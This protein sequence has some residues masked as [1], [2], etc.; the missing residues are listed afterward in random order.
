MKLNPAKC[1]FGVPAGKLLGYIVS[2]RGIEANP[3]KI[4]AIMSL[5]KPASIKDIQ[6]L[7]GCVASLSR[8]ISQLGEKAI[9]LYRL[10]RKTEKFIWD[11][12]ADEALEELKKQLSQAPILAAPKPK[13]PMLLYI[14]ANNRAVS[15]AIVVERKEEGK[16]HPLQRP[17]YYVSEVLT[18]SKQRYPHWQ[19]L[20][21][22]VFMASQKLKHYFQEH[23]IIV[24]SSA[25]LSDIIQNREATRR[26]A[27]WAIELGA[28]HIK[29]EPRAAIKSQALVDFVNDCI[30]LQAPLDKPDT[31]YWTMHFDGSRQLQGSG[32][33]VVL[34]S[35]NGEKFCYVLQL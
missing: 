25:P 26:I 28:Y 6:R 27:K 32:A 5:Q 1:T 14:S 20:V 35:P 12:E 3:E 18:S 23:P 22:G 8:F 13:E 30:E 16:E 21:L 19:K 2:E 4:N 7:T 15:A 11:A 33:S 17:V 10:L 29:Y 34:T 9:P 31:K 24:V